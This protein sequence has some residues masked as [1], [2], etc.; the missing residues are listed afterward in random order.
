VSQ[1]AA[2]NCVHDA[3]ERL[4]RWLLMTHDRS[5]GEELLLTQ[6]ALAQMLGVT[7]PTVTLVARAL[8]RAGM[9]RYTRGRVTVVDRRGLEEASCECYGLIRQ[10]YERLL[11]ATYP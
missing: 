7:R 4:A 5:D 8:Q 6:D 11:P 2:C 3:E 10:Q 1:S 9:I